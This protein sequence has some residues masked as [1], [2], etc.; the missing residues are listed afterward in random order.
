MCSDSMSR[1]V[2]NQFQFGPDDEM[3]VGGECGDWPWNG[4]RCS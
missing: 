4:R 2:G 3:G 1:A